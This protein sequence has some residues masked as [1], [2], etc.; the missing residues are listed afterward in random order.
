MGTSKDDQKQEMY[1]IV[2]SV[3]KKRPGCVLL[4]AALG[5]TSQY[6]LFIEL[7]P[8]ETWLTGLEGMAL[9]EVTEEQLR[10]LSLMAKAAVAKTANE[11]E[12]KV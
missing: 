8:H 5:G 2:F 11:P 7:F 9:Y 10:K 4:Q 6:K 12:I 3:E 1:T